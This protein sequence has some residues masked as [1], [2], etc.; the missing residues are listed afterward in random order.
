MEIAVR[1]GRH[2]MDPCLGNGSYKNHATAFQV[3]NRKTPV[4]PIAPTGF[5]LWAAKGSI[6]L[7]DLSSES[8]SRKACSKEAG[9]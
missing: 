4:S 2:I 3:L 9:S 6:T 5:H 7:W 8:P 1:G